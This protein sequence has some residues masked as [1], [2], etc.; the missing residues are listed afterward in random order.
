MREMFEAEREGLLDEFDELI[1]VTIPRH[2]LPPLPAASLP[3]MMS[4]TAGIGG[5]EAAT[6]RP[7]VFESIRAVDSGAR[8]RPS[9][10][11]FSPNAWAV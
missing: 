9:V 6:R 3:A 10:P 11:K 2:I 7:I 5:G 4:L 1:T 8:V